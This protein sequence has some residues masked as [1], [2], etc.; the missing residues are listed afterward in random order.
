MKNSRLKC[1]FFYIYHRIHHFITG[2]TRH[3]IRT[4]WL[5]LVRTEDAVDHR[6]RHISFLC[7]LYS[8]FTRSQKANSELKMKEKSNKK[9]N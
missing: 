8:S 3:E 7:R 5:F 9:K 1:F 2:I 4:R 6:D